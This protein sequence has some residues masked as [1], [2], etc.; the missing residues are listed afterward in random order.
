M[1]RK[2][3]LAVITAATMLC[4]TSAFA[5]TTPTT[6][7]FGNGTIHFSGTITN[8]PCAVAP[9]D[10]ALEVSFGQVSYRTLSVANDTTASQPIVIHLT[11]CAFDQDTATG[12]NPVGLMSKANVAFS[13]SATSDKKGY[14]STGSATN[15][16]VQLLKSDNST[17][18]DANSQPTQDDAQQLQTGNNELRFF[19]RLLATGAVQAGSVDATVNY[20]LTYL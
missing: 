12:G 7:P 1:F 5:A 6:G 15:V 10:D 14:V 19:A 11:G 2:T 3:S 8:S 13:G 18:I 20:T 17:I 16:A 4:G 9:G